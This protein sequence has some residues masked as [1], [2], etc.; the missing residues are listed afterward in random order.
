MKKLE[1]SS[2]QPDNADGPEIQTE[3]LILRRFVASDAEVVERLL[4]DREIASNTRSI[5][6]PYP[7]G[8]AI[9][10]IELHQAKWDSGKSTVFAIR[11]RETD[12]LLGGIGLEIEKS[13]HRAELGYWIGREF[14]N[15]GYCSEAAKAILEYGF[16]ELGLHRIHSHYLT[17]NPASGR[18]MEKIGMKRE[19]LLRGHARK[20]GVFEDVILYGILASD[21]RPA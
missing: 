20:W 18:V 11:S 4:N 2:T 7:P 9:I 8:A 14:W 12:Q 15:Q 3:R 1:E 16:D 10:W 21:P 17:R 13:D 5:D 6:Y 19:G